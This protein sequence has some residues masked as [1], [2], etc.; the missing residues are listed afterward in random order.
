MSRRSR[1]PLRASALLVARWHTS[2]PWMAPLSRSDTG[3]GAAR[4][5]S[6]RPV[7]APCEAV[8]DIP[9]LICGWW[10]PVSWAC[11][12]LAIVDI[13]IADPIC[14]GCPCACDGMLVVLV[15]T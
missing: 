14:G 5:G 8:C 9:D 3:T 2:N 15:R 4:G 10:L 1:S 7:V 13:G 12:A 11:N 6:H